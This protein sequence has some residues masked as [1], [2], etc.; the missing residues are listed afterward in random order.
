MANQYCLYQNKNT[1]STTFGKYYARP[2]TESKFVEMD[3]VADFIQTQ[4]SV[5]RSDVKA[6]IDEMGYAIMHFL[7]Q[8]RKIKIKGLGIFKPSVSSKPLEQLADWD[9]AKY[10]NTT[11]LLFLPDTEP[12]GGRKRIATAIKEVTWEMAEVAVDTNGQPLVGK[13]QI[14]AAKEAVEPEP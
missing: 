10:L 4:A 11:K 13:V 5:K 9:Q 8:G 3:A 14:R 6:V 12:A 7:G 1:K 2:I